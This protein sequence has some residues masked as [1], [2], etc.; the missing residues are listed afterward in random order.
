MN[1]STRDSAHAGD[2]VR[3]HADGPE[4]RALRARA[5]VTGAD[6][7]RA[8]GLPRG[9]VSAVERGAI[10]AYPKFRE[11]VS[12][13]LAARLGRSAE[14]V[15]TVAFPDAPR[16]LADTAPAP[17]VPAET[18]EALRDAGIDPE[19]VRELYAGWLTSVTG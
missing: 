18:A 15:H 11:R 3:T 8:T 14:W 4:P 13:L 19:R 7:E 2:S 12:Y 10:Y 1:V 6:V 17:H 5:G 16:L 9:V